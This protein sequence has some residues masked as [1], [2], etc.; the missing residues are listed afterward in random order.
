[1]ASTHRVVNPWDPE[2]K[3]AEL[4]KELANA[5][6]ESPGK[7]QRIARLESDPL[8]KIGIEK[9]MTEMNLE[10]HKR[11]NRDRAVQEFVKAFEI[12][13]HFGGRS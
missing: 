7:D 5:Q 8:S 2:A 4:E 3:L 11:E 13:G 12:L 6:S 9:R 1:M 10:Q